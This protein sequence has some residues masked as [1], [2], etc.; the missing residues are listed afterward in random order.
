MFQIA[1]ILGYI[2]VSF[3]TDANEGRL[4]IHVYRHKRS[5]DCL[6]KIW[7]ESNGSMSVEVVQPSLLTTKEEAA[8]KSKIEENWDDIMDNL[9]RSL[10]GVKSEILKIK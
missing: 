8:L 9:R 3:P 2:L 6:A 7:L 4:H 10:S 1:W 5:N